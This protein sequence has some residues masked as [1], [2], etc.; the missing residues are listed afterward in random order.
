MRKITLAAT[1]GI[2]LV[3]PN[4]TAAVTLESLSGTAD[5]NVWSADLTIHF[6]MFA[7]MARVEYD[8]VL[9]NANGVELERFEYSEFIDIPESDTATYS[10]GE[11]WS[12]SMDGSYSVT[13]E[14]R[15]FD[16]FSDG[17]NMTSD[18]FTVALDCGDSGPS[19][20]CVYPPRYW[21]AHPDQWP[22]TSMRVAGRTMN[23]RELLLAMTLLEN[24]ALSLLRRE[25]IAA[26]LNLALGRSADIQ[27][28]IA[29][30]DLF[31][32]RHFWDRPHGRPSKIKVNALRRALRA[33]NRQGCSDEV[34][35]DLARY[36]G[37]D[38]EPVE[39][40]VLN[41]GTVKAMYR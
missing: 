3:L 31:L 41:L 5:C 29:K 20:S 11:A 12:A 19:A 36:L 6:R 25:L 33:Y 37:V 22:L 26:R 1:L 18:S 4:L 40:E 32:T 2:L 39:V 14:F 23:Q 10:F 17:H 24:R 8:V 34:P 16:V 21:V 35:T 38:A 15:V 9:Q 7:M 30:A 28:A 13:G 27:P